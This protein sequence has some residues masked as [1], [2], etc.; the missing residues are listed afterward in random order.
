MATIKIQRESEYINFV[1]NYKVYIDEEKIGVIANRQIKE[2]DVTEGKHS[3]CFKID[4]CSSQTLSFDI[5]DKETKIFKSGGFKY[6]NLYSLIFISL[7]ALRFIFKNTFYIDFTS[8]LICL[9][10]LIIIYY[11]TFGRKK[12][13]TLTENQE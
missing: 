2:F 11:M 9:A 4:W 1:R 10:T 6:S 13:L 3:I 5:H 12:Y 7:I 8:I